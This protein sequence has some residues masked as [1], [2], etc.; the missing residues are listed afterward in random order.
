MSSLNS[1]GQLPTAQHFCIKASGVSS[2]A[3]GAAV[4]GGG[5]KG[6][7][8]N[9]V[10]QIT[11]VTQSSPTTLG[12]ANWE[13]TSFSAGLQIFIYLGIYKIQALTGPRIL[14]D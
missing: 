5:K 10:A 9:T 3:G 14:W 4:L 13:A 11:P 6:I 8:I 2:E 7:C 1:S 12:S